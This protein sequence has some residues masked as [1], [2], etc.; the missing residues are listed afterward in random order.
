MDVIEILGYSASFIIFVS[1]MMKS[2]VK[3]RIL[4]ALGCLLFVVFALKTHSIPAVV[5]NIGIVFIDIYYFYRIVRVKDNFEILEVKKDNEIVG[6][7]FDKNRPELTALFGDTAFG[8]SEKTAFY[9]R[10]ND[11][12]G[13]VAY[14]IQE[15]D[16]GKTARI[17]IDFVVAKYRDLAVGR[18]FFIN[19]LTFWHHQGVTALTVENPSKAH[20][21]YLEQLGFTQDGSASLWKKTV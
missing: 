6:Y 1:L 3:L 5:M 4:N 19:D 14:S 17:F 13:L 2:I 20:I 8:K 12:A 18:H 10:N 15:T 9:F 16:T 21:P 11:I 7:F